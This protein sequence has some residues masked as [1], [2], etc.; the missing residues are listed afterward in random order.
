MTSE[1]QKA[2]EV[3][4]DGLPGMTHNY[5][6]LSLGNI[7]SMSHR[8]QHSQPRKAAL[9]AL[10]KMEQLRQLGLIQAILPPQERPYLPALRQLGFSGSDQQILEAAYISNPTL[11]AL[12]SSASS[13]WSANAATCCPSADSLDK[14]LHITPAN[15]TYNFHRH[16]ESAQTTEV[17]RRIFKDTSRF[18]VHDPLPCSAH[19]CDEGAANHTRFCQTYENPGIHLFVFGRYADASRSAQPRNYP[20]RQTFEASEAVARLNAIPQDQLLF[21][22]QHPAAIDKGVF[23]NDVIA[24]G[25]QNVFLYHEKAFL[26]QKQLLDHLQDRMLTHCN[27]P[28]IL[29]PILEDEVPLEDAV[30]SY[31]FNSQLLTLPSG[32]MTLATPLECQEIPTVKRKIDSILADPQNP[33]QSLHTID[34]RESMQNG[35]GPGCLR[36]RIVLTTS[37]LQKIHPHV[38]LDEHL[39]HALRQWIERYYR[40]TLYPDDLRD[41]ALLEESRQAL[42]ALCQILHLG[43]LYSFQKTQ[44]SG[45][46]P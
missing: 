6:G 25:N 3:N 5:A 45:K 18:A 32:K 31:L 7:A 39:Y 33:I 1:R 16:I 38:L 30:R 24:V 35:G 41:P 4:F 19:F 20:A 46:K 12:C 8:G 36:Q 27:T 26:E 17:F 22:Q 9:Q 10:E 34:V 28:L 15:L 43:S 11:L 14:R 37:E 44:D 40:D 2:Y 23:H 42:D 29:V 21:A 13:M